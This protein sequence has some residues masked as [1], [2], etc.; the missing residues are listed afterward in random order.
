MQIYSKCKKFTTNSEIITNILNNDKLKYLYLRS[1]IELIKKN[2][3]NE[4]TFY[5]S[6]CSCNFVHW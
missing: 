6:F 2:I 4:K 1:I 3:N 5:G